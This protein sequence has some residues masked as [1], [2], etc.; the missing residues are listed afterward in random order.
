MPKILDQDPIPFGLPEFFPAAF[1]FRA[2]FKFG[3]FC[4]RFA[5]SRCKAL[6]TFAKLRSGY[7]IQVPP[8][9]MMAISGPMKLI[10]NANGQQKAMMMACFSPSKYLRT[11]Y[12]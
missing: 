6:G 9:K 1:V 11:T 8:I 3:S 12:R 7:Q 10:K 2:T 4:K 5:R